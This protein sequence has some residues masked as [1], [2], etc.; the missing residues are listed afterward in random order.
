MK[1]N[2]EEIS[3]LTGKEFLSYFQN[4]YPSFKIISLNFGVE[5]FFNED[6]ILGNS[7]IEK[8]CHINCTSTFSESDN[9]LNMDFR[10]F[11]GDSFK[12]CFEKF[13]PYYEGMYNVY[14]IEK[15]Y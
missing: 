7:T 1:V 12:E 8:V 11:S 3:D 14:R 15:K 2:G 5:F 9:D 13:K 4:K 10:G 6:E